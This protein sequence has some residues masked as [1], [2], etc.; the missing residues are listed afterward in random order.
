[1]QIIADDLAS[2]EVAALLQRH[3]DGMLANSPRDSC[4]VLDLNALR[5]PDIA[6][7]TAWDGLDLAGCGALKTLNSA[8]GEIKSM[9]THD[10]HLRKGVGAAILTHIIAQ[11]KARGMAQLS[12]ETGSSPPFQPALDLYTRF[13]F[14][15][16]P[17]FGDYREDPCSRFMTL[18]LIAARGD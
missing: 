5:S 2:P 12:L 1:M 8:H 17:P 10:D 18:D 3:H 14:R 9:R 15:Y 6:F 16:C 7:W 4:H 13:G 11:A